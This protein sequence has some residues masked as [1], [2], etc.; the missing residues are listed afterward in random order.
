MKLTEY[1]VHE[2]LVAPDDLLRRDVCMLFGGGCWRSFF[3]LGVM[4]DLQKRFPPDV[5]RTWAFTGESAGTVF[6]IAMAIGCPWQHVEELS[7]RMAAEARAHPLGLLGRGR[8][9]AGAM[10]QALLDWLPEDELVAALR[11][12]FALTLNTVA[13]T[14]DGLGLRTW[15]ATDFESREELFEAVLGSG[16]IPLFSSVSHLEAIG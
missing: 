11:G 3:F 10:L 5:L 1:L 6:A 9:I 12:R 15:L 14:A 2:G 7:C 16:N 13:L 4:R 8:S